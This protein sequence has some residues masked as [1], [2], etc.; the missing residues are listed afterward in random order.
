MSNQKDIER[1][2]AYRKMSLMGV[3]TIRQAVTLLAINYQPMMRTSELAKVIGSQ[4]A[5]AGVLAQQLKE[6]G[7]IDWTYDN[8]GRGHDRRIYHLTERGKEAIEEA[9][10]S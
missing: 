3:S 6:K 7:L 8:V 4:R 1:I 2:T 10:K 9:R 5:N